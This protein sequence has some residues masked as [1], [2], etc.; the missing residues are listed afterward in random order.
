MK[1]F[2]RFND[3]KYS[4]LVSKQTYTTVCQISQ[5]SEVVKWPDTGGF[6]MELPIYCVY[7]LQTLYAIVFFQVD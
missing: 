5:G 7:D 6:Y 4:M 2:L 1:C 3:A